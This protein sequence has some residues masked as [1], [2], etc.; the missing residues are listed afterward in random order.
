MNRMKILVIIGTRPEA[1]KMCPIVSELRQD[2]ALQVYFCSTGQ[3]REMLHDVLPIFGHNLDFDLELMCKSRSL[4]E[5][6]GNMMIKFDHLINELDPEL[7]LVHGDTS[8][9]AV[10]SMVAFYNQKKVAHVEAGLRTFNLWSPWPEEG[11][12]KII[13][14]LAYHH[15]A[16]TKIAEKNLIN[17][18]VAQEDITIAGNTVLDAL[19]LTKDTILQENPDLIDENSEKKRI[20]VTLHRRENHGSGLENICS[21]INSIS[22]RSDVEIVFPV[23]PNPDVRSTVYDAIIRRE[24]VFLMEPLNYKD[25]V[26]EM[27]KSHFILSDS[28]G[29]QEEAPSLN[30]PILITRD[31]SERPEVVEI[32][33]AKLVGDDQALIEKYSN[34]LLYNSDFY[35]QMINHK[36]PYGDGYASQRIA[37]KIQELL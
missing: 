34:L 4:S 22:S 13:G 27:M 37:S 23:H 29:V 7:I 10:A 2:P 3:H 36:N 17:E 1:I 14:A 21:A 30:K 33:A 11:N 12:R 15:F 9:A 20:L 28:G 26:G 31:T 16:V 6:S 5:F 32:G 19:R 25:F 8:S 24:N 35:S 18:G